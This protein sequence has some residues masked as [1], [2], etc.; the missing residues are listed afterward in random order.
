MFKSLLLA[1]AMTVAFSSN[2][3]AATVTGS[4]V[5]DNHA[6]VVLDDGINP[7]AIVTGSGGSWPSAKTFNFNIPDL[8]ENQMKR[9]KIHIIAWGD[10]SSAQG[11]AA[12]FT[13]AMSASTGSG[14]FVIGSVPNT[15]TGGNFPV[16]GAATSL[17]Q[18][19]SVLAGLGVQNTPGWTSTGSVGTGGISGTWGPVVMAALGPNPAVYP[20][21]FKFIWDT[22]A[23]SANPKNYRV[24]SLPCDQL[25]KPVEN[26]YP[27]PG[28]HWQC[29]RVAEGPTLKPESLI[30][31]D[32]FG[33]AEIVLARP[34]MLCNPSL[35]VHGDKKYGI[36]T[37]ER[38]LVCYQPVKQS[39]AQ[40]QRKVKINNQMAPATLVLAERQMF[41]VPSIKKR[42]DAP[43]QPVALPMD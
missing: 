33:K 31:R 40:T 38:H 27:V 24:A 12:H 2:A 19:N 34:L 7:K 8:D 20:S 16:N 11:I 13:G 18:V 35:K 25:Q 42:L 39:D 26:P 5:A 36:E 37:P 15:A 41:C 30:V 4:V 10:G 9:C 32:Q 21:N 3:M 6:V 22:P 29:Y 43:D 1:T 23:L 28:N 17:A 14:A